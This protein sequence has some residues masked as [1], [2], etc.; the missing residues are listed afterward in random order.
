[1][2]ASYC[3]RYSMNPKGPGRPATS[4]SSVTLNTVPDDARYDR[5]DHLIARIP[6]GKRC[7]GEGCSSSG[8]TMCNKC[9]VGLCVDCFSIFHTK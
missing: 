6:G 9:N 7:A 2:I 1:M 4:K 3:M 5:I 8:R